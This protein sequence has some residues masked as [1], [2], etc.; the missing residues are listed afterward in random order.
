M[1]NRNKGLKY[2][3]IDIQNG[4]NSYRYIKQD[5]DITFLIKYINIQEFINENDMLNRELFKAI[6]EENIDKVKDLIKKGANVNFVNFV[7][8]NFDGNWRFSPLMLAS[9]KGNIKIVELLLNNGADIN[10]SF[11]DGSPYPV[12]FSALSIASAYNK[13][14]VIKI[15]IKRGINLKKLGGTVIADRRNKYKSKIKI[16]KLL[17]EAGA[18]INASVY[19]TPL[20]NAINDCNIDLIN[21]LF[22]KGANPNAI[23]I[24][25]CGGADSSPLM[26]AVS[27]R[28]NKAIDILL[29]KNVNINYRNQYGGSALLYA[30]SSNNLSLANL[31]ISKGAHVKNQFFSTG[32]GATSDSI[33]MIAIQDCPAIVKTLIEKGADIHYKKPNCTENCTALQVAKKRG[34]QN[35]VNLLIQAGAR[36]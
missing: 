17:I 31:L 29:E 35:I 7:T 25:C 12:L 26:I 3:A 10:Y 22:D 27:R 11:H 9:K 1:K 14:E 2:L 18:D 16:L 8:I 36:E 20:I 5:Q 30:I 21:Y 34:L 6:D 23:E 15:L 19:G 33:L 28:C 13:I 24:G 32:F 4:Y